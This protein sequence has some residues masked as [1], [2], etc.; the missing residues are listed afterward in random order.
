MN[1]TEELIQAD[2][3]TLKNGGAPATHLFMNMCKRLHSM[4]ADDALQNWVALG[5]EFLPEADR[6]EV[7]LFL[8]TAHLP[9]RYDERASAVPS[10]RTNLH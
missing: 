2:L 6:A 9:P 4:G 7:V 5:M 3:E 8:V 1:P 10:Q